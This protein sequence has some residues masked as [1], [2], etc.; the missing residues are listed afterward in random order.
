MAKTSFVKVMGGGPPVLPNTPVTPPIPAPRPVESSPNKPLTPPQRPKSEGGQEALSVE[1]SPNESEQDQSPEVQQST[2]RALAV[3]TGQAVGEFDASDFDIPDLKLAQ[4]VGPLSQDLGFTPGE[5]VLKKE[6]VLW[7]PES[8]NPLEITVLKLKKQFIENLEYASDVPSRIFD[9][10]IEVRE[11]GGYIEW[12]NNEEPTF[13]PMATCLILIKKPKDVVD[14]G[15]AFN[16][17]FG[18][19]IYTQAMWRLQGNGYKNAATK[20][21]TESRLRLKDGLHLAPFLLE[22]ALKKGKRNSYWVP[23]LKNGQAHTPEFV[24]F[25]LSNCTI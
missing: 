7:S 11:A 24:Q 2:I 23:K 5:L 25:A 14:D 20:I 12:I 4:Y 6:L 17:E 3:Q 19:D 22:P 10:L 8:A 21:I 16:L 13:V 18:D 15:G 9:T 1:S